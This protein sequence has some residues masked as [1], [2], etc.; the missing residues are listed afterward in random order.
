MNLHVVKLQTDPN[1]R[2]QEVQ[3]IIWVYTICQNRLCGT[4]GIDVLNEWIPFKGDNSCQH[5]WSDAP[6]SASVRLGIE[7]FDLQRYFMQTHW[8]RQVFNRQNN[9]GLAMQKRVFGLMRTV[10]AQISLRIRAVWSGLS[11]SANRIIGYYMIYEWRACA[12]MKRC[13]AHVQ[14]VQDN[15]H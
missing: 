15:V 2:P 9:M 1:Q 6:I 14:D 8:F 4:L 11:L 12:R 7:V 3:S 13:V 5:W 10:K